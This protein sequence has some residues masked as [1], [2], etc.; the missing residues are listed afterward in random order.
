MDQASV[1]KQ[2]VQFNKSTFDNT[3]NA[4]EMAREQNARML[5][6]YLEQASWM[7]EEGKKS[8]RQWLDTYKKGCEDLKSMMDESYDRVEQ[9]LE[10]GAS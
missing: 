5:N 1:L 2:M 3:Y 6:A 8:I 7:P 4:L 9:T 10:K